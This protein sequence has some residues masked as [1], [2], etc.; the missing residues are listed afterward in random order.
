MNKAQLAE[1]LMNST[2]EFKDEYFKKVV[3]NTGSDLVRTAFY[4]I[5]T[6]RYKSAIRNALESM[7]DMI[8]RILTS[9]GLARKE[10]HKYSYGLSGGGYTLSLY[11]SVENEC[12]IDASVDFIT[13][14]NGMYEV[15]DN[16]WHYREE[17]G[18]VSSRIPGNS[19]YCKPVM[20]TS[21]SLWKIEIL[22]K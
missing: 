2:I 13:G 22:V 21:V 3:F 1:Q 17:T 11:C 5:D 8:D 7:P 12:G 4:N 18:N 19:D 9:A 6:N 14:S 20:V 10:G 15:I 16:K